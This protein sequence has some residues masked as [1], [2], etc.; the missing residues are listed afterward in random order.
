MAVY[1]GACGTR[2]YDAMENEG[3]FQTTGED[4]GGWDVQPMNPK[5]RESRGR[6]EDTCMSCARILRRVVTETA[7]EIA[8]KNKE[9]VEALK[10]EMRE[11]RER[12]ARIDAEKATFEKEWAERRRQLGL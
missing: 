1:C 4:F 5:A 3:G 10:K 8:T 6:I 2:L 11:Y 9:R 12:Q 7:R